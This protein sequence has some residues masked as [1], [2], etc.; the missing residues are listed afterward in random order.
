MVKNYELR[1]GNGTKNSLDGGLCLNEETSL[2]V[3]QSPVL[4]NMC[5]DNG[6]ILS[7]RDGQ[8][9]IFNTDLSSTKI[10]GMYEFKDHIYY[11][12][13]GI[14]YKFDGST[15]TK[16]SGKSLGLNDVFM[17]TYNGTL[18]FLNG[19][20]YYCLIDDVVS[21]ITPYIPRVSYNRKPDG[22][23][24]EIDESWNMIS[25]QFRNT[26][27]GDGTT[28][29]YILS[30]DNLKSVDKV[31]IG[32]VT[33][34]EFTVDLVKGKVSFT[35]APAEG[36]NNVEITASKTF[37]KLKE[38]ITKCTFA[39]EFSNR[40]FFSGN[41]DYPNQYYA[42]GLSDDNKANYF[43]QKYKYLIGGTDKKI[44]AFKVRHNKLVVFKE[45][46]TCTVDSATGLDNL[47][48]FPITFLNTDVGCDIP[49]SVQL[50]NND[51][52]FAN[53]YQGINIIVSTYI[54]G[55]SNIVTLSQN[56][57]GNHNRKGLL[58]ESNLKNAKSVDYNFKYHLCLG[59][60]CYVLDYKDGI[61]TKNTE[62]NKWFLYDNIKAN[63]FCVFKNELYYGHNAKGNLVKFISQK[64]DFGEGINAV[65]K[66]KLFDFGYPDYLKIISE[67]YATFSNSDN[68]RN[69]IDVTYTS[70]NGTIEKTLTIGN[71][72]LWDWNEFDW[73]N[74]NWDV[75]LFDRTLKDKI[76]LKKVVYMQLTFENSEVN[77]ELSIKNIALTFRLI[78][79][80]K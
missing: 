52:I 78:R 49:N 27:N 38:N 21:E 39:I 59:D 60:K 54:Q 45:D 50:I 10:Q 70:E 31:T 75:A 26:F 15:N 57:N 37:D 6:G 40:M 18:Y 12:T 74:F 9:F 69:E 8:K 5:L 4:L 44:T 20:N 28:K 66:S 61:S 48:S 71:A 16:L 68:S 47:A 2:S 64:N 30:L 41:S 73:E 11:V 3:S 36:L 7:K 19:E 46:M 72:S 29:D 58:K 76:K 51:I 23:G 42:G 67:L 34:T 62:E 79:K 32:G 24:G 80:V 14:L 63:C 65:W 13:N 17:F 33:T 25:D 56:I 53:T 35:T 22:S 1:M 55:E 77:Q 43:P